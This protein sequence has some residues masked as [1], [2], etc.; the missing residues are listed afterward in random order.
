M[1]AFMALIGIVLLLF[2]IYLTRLYN[3][4]VVIKNQVDNAWHQIDV[5]LNR[6]S[7]LIPRLVETVIAYAKHEQETL[8]R[9]I[10]ARSGLITARTQNERTEA[11]NYLSNT[12]KSLFAVAE[13]YPELKADE[14]FRAFQMELT[15]TE[16]RLNMSRQLYNDMVSVYNMRIEAFPANTLVGIWGFSRRGYFLIQES[17]REAPEV[18][19]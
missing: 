7:D 15:N 1:I 12:L 14:N 11:D 4:I 6:R 5:E 18:K 8:T 19:F 13:N 10:E 3:S 2:T 16:N 9:V 17:V